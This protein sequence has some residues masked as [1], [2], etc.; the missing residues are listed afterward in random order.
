LEASSLFWLGNN[1][2]RDR[3]ATKKHRNTRSA[4]FHRILTIAGK[5]SHLVAW[6]FTNAFFIIFDGK[7]FLIYFFAF[8]IYKKKLTGALHRLY[9]K[10]KCKVYKRY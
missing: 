9:G 4:K 6:F 7:D 1:Y 5:K 8:Q 2:W 3:V 10:I